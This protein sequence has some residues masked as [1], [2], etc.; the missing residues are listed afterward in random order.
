MVVSIGIF[1]FDNSRNMIENQYMKSFDNS[2]TQLDSSVTEFLMTFENAVEMFSQNDMIRDL[3]E[4]PDTNYEPVQQLFKSFQE[5]HQYTAYAYYVPVKPILDEK[6]LITWPDTSSEL[7]LSNWQPKLRPWY[8]NAI[9]A[10]GRVVWTKPYE[11]A[12]TGDDMVTVSRMV[13]DQSGDIEGI[14]A[15]DVF[16]DELSNKVE[17][18]KAFNH[19]SAFLVD[20]SEVGYVF[21][22]KDLSTDVMDDI[23]ESDWIG[24]LYESNFGLFEMEHNDSK[25]Y[26]TYTTSQVTGWKVFGVVEEK[27]ILDETMNVLREVLVSTVIVLSLGLLCIVYISKQLSSSVKDIGHMIQVDTHSDV[28]QKTSSLTIGFDKAVSEVED[29]NFETP[30]TLLNMLFD[31]ETEMEKTQELMSLLDLETLDQ[32]NLEILRESAEKLLKIRTELEAET[33]Q[34]RE[35]QIEQINRILIQVE[36]TLNVSFDLNV[37][38]R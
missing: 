17:N 37:R 14:I 28:D 5:S 34:R 11:D 18:F 1:Y 38:S 16:L 8:I 3:S 32:S 26:V 20:Q 6:K 2:V 36:D 21:I 15:I 27:K 25:Y 31:S 12:T 23:L 24:N 35:Y 10:D 13:Y 9:D 29:G 4:G 30:R 7:E 33:S 19:G 22:T